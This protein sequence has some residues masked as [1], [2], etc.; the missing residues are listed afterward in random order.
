MAI[1]DLIKSAV[2]CSASHCWFNATKFECLTQTLHDPSQ[3]MLH[4]NISDPHGCEIMSLV[5][6]ELT[7][8]PHQALLEKIR[9]KIDKIERR[10][11]TKNEDYYEYFL[12]LFWAMMNMSSSDR[13]SE[14][15]RHLTI[16][17]AL[18]LLQQRPPSQVWVRRVPFR[19]VWGETCGHAVQILLIPH[20]NTLPHLI[21]YHNTLPLLLTVIHHTSFSYLFT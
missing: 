5:I 21:I 7:W 12:V 2:V 13:N 17:T 6:T 18:L 20:H 19:C 15:W 16:C 4:G 9:E 14:W 3:V 8:M 10:N 11:G 1:T